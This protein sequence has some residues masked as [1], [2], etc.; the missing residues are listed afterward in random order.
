M[1]PELWQRLKPLFHAALDR[2]PAERA[3]FIDGACAHDPELKMHLNDLVH[4][5]EQSTGSLGEQLVDLPNM[6]NSG[7]VRFQAG[8]LILDRFRIVRSLGTGGMGEVYKAVDLH[9]GT[10]A[11]KTIRPAIASSKGALERFRQEVQLARRVSGPQ[12]CRIHELFLLPATDKD[13]PTAFLTMEF[14]DGLTL[15]SKLRD[16][17]PMAWKEALPVALEICEGLRLIHE[18]GIIHRDLKSGNIMVC[19]QNG[20][21]RTVLMDFGLAHDFSIQSPSEGTT[22]SPARF[23]TM[24]GAVM[25]TPAYMAPEQFEG[26]PVSPATDIYAFGIILYELVTG[27]HPYSANTPI[28]AAIRRARQPKPASS[29]QRAIPRHWDR[30]IERC[31]EFEPE[32]RFQ[33]A[34]EVAKALRAGPANLGNIRKDRPWVIWIAYALMAVFLSRSAYLWWEARQQYHPSAEALRWYDTGLS[35]LREGNYTRATRS[36]DAALSRDPHFVMAH[37]RMAEAW[38]NLDFQSDAQREMLIAAPGERYLAPTDQ[39]YFAAIHATITG[40]FAGAVDVYRKILQRLPNTDRPAGYVD[41]GMAYER[42]GDPQHAL[43]NYALASSPDSDNAASSMHTGILESRLHQAPAANQAFDRAE[44][45]FTAE[46]NAEGL[47]ELDYERGYAANDRGDAKSAQQLLQ[48]SL[49][50]AVDIGSIQLQIRVLSQLSSATVRFDPPKAAEYAQQAIRLARDNRLDA[51]AANGLVRLAT[52]QIREH[53]FKEA[54]D[55]VNEGLKLAQESQQLRA[56]ALAN[57]TLAN[58]MDQEHHPDQ[59]IAPA[60]SALNYYQKNGFFIPAGVESMMLIRAEKDKG[61]YD[62]ALTS[63]NAFLAM[64]SR[65]ELPDLLR[66][67]E[68]LLGSVLSEMERYPDALVHFLNAKKLADAASSEQFEAVY[69]ADIL[70]RQ[71]R[72]AECEEMLSFKPATEPI[73]IS[74]E[75]ERVE[76]RLSQAKYRNSLQL[77][78][79][80]PREHPEMDVSDQEELA[81]DKAIAESHLHQEKEAFSDLKASMPDETDDPAEIAARNMAIAE[82]NLGTGHA[83]TALDA[84]TKAAAQFKSAGQLDSELLSACLGASAAKLTGNSVA[85]TAFSNEV[86]DIVTEIQQ[87]WTPQASQTYLSRPDI[88]ISMQQSHLAPRTMHASK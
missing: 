19:G 69:A 73:H 23:R 70:R 86:V 72:F 30:I 36:L 88:Q 25:G 3:Q 79:Q 46:E 81:L 59:V 26:G 21:I 38:S 17:G 55:S 35:A 27:T 67:A 50:E 63:A 8:Q 71:G 10:I 66:L 82:V 49:Q 37:V 34:A 4:A 14:L 83:Q 78:Q 48:K 65:S 6:L 51:W 39:M 57:A 54:E 15:A 7:I 13:P 5:E 77:A 74:V 53:Q 11:L 87:T 52:A 42:A 75:L 20:S 16:D 43:E 85:F 32:K 58:L 22:A 18:K 12:V 41:L 64:A 29:L 40:D 33:S 2:D 9:L 68:E 47:A 56:E 24:A 62:Q 60:R 76:S 28:A 61:H 84:A 1:T 80:M 31:L 44:K 45:I